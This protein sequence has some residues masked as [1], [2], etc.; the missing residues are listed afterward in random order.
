MMTSNF[1]SDEAKFKELILYV[2]ER[3][4]KDP[5]Y[6]AVKLNK[7]LFYS[8]FA[9][10]AQTGRPITGVQWRKYMNGPA[11]AS[12]KRFK[13]ELELANDA[14]E[15]ESVRLQK[16]LLPKRSPDLSKFTAE[17]VSVIDAIIEECWDMNGTQLSAKSH[18]HAGWR[19]AADNEEIPYFTVYIPDEAVVLNEVERS[20]AVEVA[21]RISPA[22]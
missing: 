15:Y 13:R 3:C 6:G 5:D 10:Y 22:A 7:I 1:K 11:P 9:F 21:Q 12:M 20:W 2:A 19:L 4:F 18:R 17:E 16:Q 14:Y 8:E